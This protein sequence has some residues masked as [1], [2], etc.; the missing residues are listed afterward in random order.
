M[1]GFNAPPCTL[2]LKPQKDPS[3]EIEKIFQNSPLQARCDLYYSMYC[4]YHASH[5][6]VR[7]GGR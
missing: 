5:D 3:R 4:L 2:Y 7:A 6:G 1:C